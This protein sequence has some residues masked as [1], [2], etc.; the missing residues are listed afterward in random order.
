[1]QNNNVSLGKRLTLLLC[2]V[3]TVASGA[4]IAPILPEIANL[5][6]SEKLAPYAM[7][8][9]NLA[10]MIF[11][12]FIGQ[13]LDKYG[14]LAFMRVGLL[15]YALLGASGYVM[16]DNIYYLLGLRFAFGI[17]TA[18]NMTAIST[19]VADYFKDDP[20]G[21]AQFSGYQ[22]T[23][24][25]LSA[26]VVIQ[27]GT[28]VAAYDF[29]NTFLIY[30]VAIFF[31]ILTYLFLT[32]PVRDVGNSIELKDTN[33]KEK[34][35]TK[36]VLLILLT[37][38]LGM[39]VYYAAMVYTPFVMSKFGASASSTG[40][41]INLLTA[42][43][44]L[45]A[46]FYGKLKANKS[47]DFIY[48]T[49]FG[50]IFIGYA[51]MGMSTNI[52]TLFIGCAVSGLGV[53]LLMP[54]SAVRLMSTVSPSIMGT[55]MGILIATVFGGNFSAGLLAA[56]IIPSL[57]YEGVFIVFGVIAALIASFYGIKNVKS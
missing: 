57:G 10:M 26:V 34:V 44:A 29:K 37:L 53:G 40:I 6:G 17:F 1:M 12:P 36:D 28:F 55:A 18:L 52:V 3:C 39:A 20:Q 4:L 48:M 14:R 22:G 16:V 27:L 50:L 13:L 25:S 15:G 9:P 24:A 2:G 35:L 31:L 42:L 49:S 47:F 54:N 41:A 51:L 30:F 43:S 19:L 46:F 56:P 23:F 32:E 8:L 38:G 45:S 7:L 5:T 21:R 11:A 33:T